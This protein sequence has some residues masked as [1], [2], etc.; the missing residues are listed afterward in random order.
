MIKPAQ[1]SSSPRLFI[2]MGVS[3]TGKS[4]L[5]KQLANEISAT[6]LDADDFHSVQAKKHMAANKPLT[7]EMRKPWLASIISHLQLLYQQG[8]S[9]VLAYSG[10]KSAHRALFRELSFCCHF[11]YLTAAKAVI[12]KRM[13][14][15]ESHFFSATL[16]DSQ[17]EA[18]EVPLLSEQDISAINIERSFLSVADEINNLAQL[19]TKKVTTRKINNV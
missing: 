13:S 6:F 17:F 10:L 5:A 9:V 3:G 15:R 19:I 18:M 7:D 11:F 14:E 2:V 4:S 16:L 8:K 12:A 1:T